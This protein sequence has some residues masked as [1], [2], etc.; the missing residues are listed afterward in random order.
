[1]WQAAHLEVGPSEVPKAE[2]VP[3][4]PSLILLRPTPSLT[5]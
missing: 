5:V 4:G 1:M 3:A 2:A